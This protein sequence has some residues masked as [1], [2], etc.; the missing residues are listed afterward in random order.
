MGK[1]QPSVSRSLAML[2]D[3]LGLELFEP[4]RRPLKPTPICL[5]LA[6]EGRRILQAGAAASQMV[7]NHQEGRSGAVRL[8]GTPVFMDGVV[9]TMIAGFQSAF[10]NI[11]IDQT[12]GYSAQVVDGLESGAIDLGILPIRDTEVPA[13]LTHARVLEGRNVIACRVGHP[14]ARQGSVTLAE[15]SACSWI[16]PPSESPLYH[17]L[18]AVLQ[19]I[20]VQDFKIS[21]SGGSLSAVTSILAASDSLTVL[22][23]SVV[24]M[25]RRHNA[26]AALSVRIG[27]PDRHLYVLS[28][29]AAQA[30]PAVGRFHRF[31]TGE[32]RS[33]AEVIQRREQDLLWRK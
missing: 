30:R 14:L 3:R 13:S 15:I 12:Y 6:Q 4:G 24:H 10:P 32:F 18:S 2:E 28:T 16:A 31:M 7:H 26:V 20:G 9:A 11:R 21:Y 27:D 23:Y 5:T 19:S 17:D 1:S 25:L 33:L 8:A 29:P 22:P